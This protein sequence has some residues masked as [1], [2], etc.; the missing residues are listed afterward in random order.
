MGTKNNPGKF[1]CYADA[2]D[3][4]PMFVLLARDATAPSIVRE[5]AYMRS[6]AINR[7]EKPES[8]RAT[9]IEAFA[10]SDA[11]DTWRKASRP[12]DP[13]SPNFGEA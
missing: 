7:G 2:D 8:D 3:D 4:E 10:C 6:D 9:V 1:D 12:D 11:M 5:W 13:E